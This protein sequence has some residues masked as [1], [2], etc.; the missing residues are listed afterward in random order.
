[1]S[2]AEIA[3]S[4]QR[5]LLRGRVFYV[6]YNETLVSTW[7]VVASDPAR[8]QRLRAVVVDLR[9]NGGGDNHTYADLLSA[10]QRV[11]KTKRIVVLI[12]RATFSA[13]ENF[14]AELEHV[15][16]PV[17]VGETSGGSPNLYGDT[18]NTPLPESGVEFRVAGKYWQKS[19]AGDPRLAIELSFRFR[20][21]RP[22]SSRGAIPC[23]QL[24]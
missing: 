15:A 18:I 13:A 1:M 22:H 12:S 8:E 24:V 5:S 6:G 21:R 3:S 2:R 16:K 19:T 23:S 14:A 17:F 20:S 10:L 4:G 7:G 9:N 11:S